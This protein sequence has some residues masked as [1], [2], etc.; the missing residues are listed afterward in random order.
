MTSKIIPCGAMEE[1]D[2]ITSLVHSTRCNW[3]FLNLRG[4]GSICAVEEFEMLRNIPYIPRPLPEMA[5]L[6]G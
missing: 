4:H 2:E 1:V 3:F 5:Q 6:D